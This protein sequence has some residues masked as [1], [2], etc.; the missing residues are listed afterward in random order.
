M[1]RFIAPVAACLLASV[2]F[3][4]SVR[5]PARVIDGDTLEIGSTIIRLAD[6]DAPELGQ[7]CDGPKKLSSCGRVAA[8]FLAERIEGQQIE[9]DVVAIDDYGRSIASCIHN[10]EELSS[11]MVREGY[12]LAFVRFSDRYAADEQAARAQQAGLW[13]ATVEPPWEFRAKRWEFAAQEAPEGCPIKGNISEHGRI[14]HAPWSQYYD[15]TKISVNQG[16]RWFCTEGEALAAGW[17]PPK[18]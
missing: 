15:R 7:K 10:G 9:C 2:A 12:A 3:A 18:R 17:R 4:D 16:E 13:R 5:G 14:Y 11:W 1:I 6:I 8:D